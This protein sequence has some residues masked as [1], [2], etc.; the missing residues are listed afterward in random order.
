MQYKHQDILLISC[1]SCD[2]LVSG[3]VGETRAASISRASPDRR[4][5]KPVAK[6]PQIEIDWPLKDEFDFKLACKLCFQKFG[7]GVKGYSY[8]PHTHSCMKNFFLI[9]LKDK[10]TLNWLR[11]RP[12]AESQIHRNASYKICQQ[13]QNSEPCRVGEERCTFPHHQPEARLW[14]MDRDGKFIIVEFVEHLKKIGV[15]ELACECYS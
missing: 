11:V 7:D 10:E 1:S 9:R 8:N 12:R 13:F 3:T 2:I 15:G 14:A 5:P 6:P 4:T